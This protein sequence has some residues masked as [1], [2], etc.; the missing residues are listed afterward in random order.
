MKRPGRRPR[1][2]P[3]GLSPADEARVEALTVAMALAPGVYARNRMFELFANA[4]VK[5][6]KSRAATLRGIVKH[7]G[8][9]CALTLEREALP[10]RLDGGLQ[11]RER[12]ARLHGDDLV[13]RGVL[14]DAREALRPEDGVE[15]P[16]ESH[17]ACA[18][19]TVVLLD[20]ARRA[21]MKTL[22]EDGWR[23]VRQGITTVEEVLSVTTAKEVE[24]TTKNETLDAAAKTP[25]SIAV[26]R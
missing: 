12:E 3:V 25:A 11:R 22:A 26:S 10:V 24:R 19:G 7:L 13:G 6:A 17:A 20:A 23:L 21:G 5:R 15:R 4:G 8:R 14:D 1:V 2:S 9:A 16:L 18:T